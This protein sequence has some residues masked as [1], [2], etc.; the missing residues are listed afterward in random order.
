MRVAQNL[1]I[2]T[3]TFTRPANTTAYTAGD[4]VSDNASTTTPITLAD[5][6]EA[7]GGS[8]NIVAARLSTNVV[9]LTPRIRVHL[10]NAAT[11]TVSADN[12]AR[13][14]TYANASLRLGYFDFAAMISGADTGNS[15]MSYAQN[16]ALAVP[17]KAASTST[18]IY[19]VLETLDGFTPASGQ[20]FTLTLT[21]AA[22]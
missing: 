4:V 14:E 13:R 12:A 11:A 8:G 7:D 19:A 20:S 22:N 1:K 2:V 17:I 18:T 9:S 6:V 16:M 3:A 10:F 15:D 5:V 21:V